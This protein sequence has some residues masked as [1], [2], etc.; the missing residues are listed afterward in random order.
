MRPLQLTATRPR[1]VLLA[2]RLRSRGVKNA[3][4]IVIECRHRHGGVIPASLGAALQEQESRG[5]NI[6]GADHGAPFRHQPVTKPR[7]LQLVRHV[8]A[9][10]VSNGVGPMQL[11]FLPFIEEANRDGGAWKPAV[12]IAT[13]LGIIAGHVRQHGVRNGLATY[14][15]GSPQSAAGQQYAR[16]VMQRQQ[17]LSGRSS[18]EGREASRPEPAATFEGVPRVL[19]RLARTRHGG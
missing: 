7:V 15:A 1:D 18:H 12:N 4:R 14:N 11:T 9:G 10:G 16:E 17:R 19:R 3:L 5:R 13:G 6:F 2:R 8:R